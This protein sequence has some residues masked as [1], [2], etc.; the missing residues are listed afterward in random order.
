MYEF[1]M[2]YVK[3]SYVKD[4]LFY[5]LII[6]LFCKNFDVHSL[7]NIMNNVLSKVIDC[8]FI[9]KFFNN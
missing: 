2:G 3:Y 5:L 1:Y 9:N 4:S 6:P 8:L 7:C